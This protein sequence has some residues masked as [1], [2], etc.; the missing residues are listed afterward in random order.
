MLNDKRFMVVEVSC[1][2]L[3]K[4]PTV[5]DFMQSRRGKYKI[6]SVS[7]SDSVQI[8]DLFQGTF[9]ISNQKTVRD[10]HETFKITTPTID[11]VLYACFMYKRFNTEWPWAESTPVV[12]E[13]DIIQCKKMKSCKNCKAVVMC[14]TSSHPVLYAAPL[15][16]KGNSF[17]GNT[18]QLRMPDQILRAHPNMW[19]NYKFL[20]ILSKE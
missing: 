5:H 18:F 4:K 6:Y 9:H 13:R 11:H 3:P 15:W 2:S 8:I 20:K 16:P 17:T 7:Q 19:E 1:T 12:P 14:H 10:I